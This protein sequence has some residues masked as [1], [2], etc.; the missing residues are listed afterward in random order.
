MSCK[1]LS[2]ISHEKLVEGLLIIDSAIIFN[3]KLVSENY[4]ISVAFIKVKRVNRISF[5]TCAR[6]H[7]G[8][9]YGLF[10]LFFLC[11]ATYS[12]YFYKRLDSGTQREDIELKLLL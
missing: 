3:D 11:V 6:S 2:H 4:P 12:M 8:S 7:Q 9:I 5:V 1:H 10:E